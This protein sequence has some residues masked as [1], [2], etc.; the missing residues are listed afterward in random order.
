M[1][2]HIDL[3][4]AVRRKLMETARRDGFLS[5]EE[6]AAVFDLCKRDAVLSLAPQGKETPQ[7]KKHVEV[8]D[9]ARR[10]YE[11]A[12]KGMSNIWAWDDRGLDDEHPG[13]RERY[14]GYARSALATTESNGHE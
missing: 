5:V 14:L 12:H 1:N 6:I 8:E 7:P 4:E 10:I 9:V 3:V 13:A 2:D 11:D